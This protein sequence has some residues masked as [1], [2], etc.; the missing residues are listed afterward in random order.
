MP[1]QLWAKLYYRKSQPS[2]KTICEVGYFD[3]VLIRALC[4]E[5][6]FSMPSRVSFEMLHDMKRKYLL[7]L[8]MGQ[9]ST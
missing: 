6:E 7:Q 5:T 2:E 9:P 8:E 1:L 3:L 4:K